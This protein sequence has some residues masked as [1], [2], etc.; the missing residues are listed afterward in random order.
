[1]RAI[2]KKLPV[3]G[4]TKVRAGREDYFHLR[5]QD[6]VLRYLPLGQV[7]IRLHQKDT[8]F[9]TLVRIAAARIAG[10]TVIVSR[11]P[12]LS[13]QAAAFLADREGRRLLGKRHGRRPG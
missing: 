9:E 7:V 13:N 12:D 3:L 8:L 6:N 11:P 4:G 1:M 5:G 10:C 2:P